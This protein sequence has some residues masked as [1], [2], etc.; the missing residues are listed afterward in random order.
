MLQPPARF[1][2]WL[3]AWQQRLA[4]PLPGWQAHRR[5]APLAT[6]VDVPQALADQAR[7]R[8]APP[9]AKPSSVLVLL[10]PEQGTTH[11]LLTLRSHR[12][13]S[14]GGQLSL[15]GGRR[16]PGET[17][18]EAALREA[19]EEVGLPPSMATVVGR[20]SPLYIPVSYSLLTPVVALAPGPCPWQLN[21]AEVAEVL[22]LPLTQLHHAGIRRTEVWQLMGR[23]YQ[24]PVW[25]VHPQVPLWGAT[26]M[27]LA[28]LM[29]VAEGPGPG[30]H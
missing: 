7:R 19:E 1:E 2:Q 6:D 13:N 18:E 4:A 30:G 27:V 23:P 26:A 29:A 3:E 16:E 20:L 21:P 28:E 9:D 24:V 25:Q 5:A 8:Q 15:P 17:D 22:P 14:H 11:V 12:L 10:W